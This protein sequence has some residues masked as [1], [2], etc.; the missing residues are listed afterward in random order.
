[1]RGASWEALLLLL[2]S[3]EMSASVALWAP[4]G[5][6]LRQTYHHHC[7]LVLCGPGGQRRVLGTSELP[8]KQFYPCVGLSLGLQHVRNKLSYRS[9][10]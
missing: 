5:S 7:F 6:I 10:D 2:G 3:S 9:M 4:K 8:V 1:M